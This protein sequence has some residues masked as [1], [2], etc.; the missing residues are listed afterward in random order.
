MPIPQN[1]AKL[2]RLSAKDRVFQQ[3]Q[4][5]IV[6]GTIQP[7]EKLQDAEIAEALG[8]S[9]TPVR[10]ALQLLQVMGFVEMNPGRDTRVTTIAKDDI[11][12]VYPVLASLHALA[13]ELAAA[14]IRPEQLARLRRINDQFA[15]TLAQ[16]EAYQ[17]MELDEQFHGE[18]LDAAANPYITSFSGTLQMHIRRL[19]YVFLQRPIADARKS[20]AE[21]AAI[22]EA[23]ERRDGEAAAA[24]MKQNWLRP[25][26]EIYRL[27]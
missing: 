5:W 7:G 15:A 18:I 22:V 4:R 14:A 16:K 11:L 6:D 13:A 3:L 20:V 27:I 23:L 21:H 24:L 12:K 1:Q 9:R 8:V 25:M 10:E 2:P 19:K 17:A 26:H